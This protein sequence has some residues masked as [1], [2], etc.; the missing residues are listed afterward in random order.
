MSSAAPCIS[1][2]RRSMIQRNSNG[3]IGR[4]D[5]ENTHFYEI[6]LAEFVMV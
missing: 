1:W 2:I 6:W 5:S 3:G 4:T